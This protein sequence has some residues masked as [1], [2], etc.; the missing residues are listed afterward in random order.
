MQF[1]LHELAEFLSGESSEIPGPLITG[2]LPIEYGGPGV[3]TYI[4]DGQFLKRLSASSCGAVI[5]SAGVDCGQTPCIRSRNPEADYARLTSLYYS[6]EKPQWGISEKAHISDD[7]EVAPGVSIGP[8]AVIGSRARI[9]D[10]TVIDAHAVIGSDVTVGRDCKIFPHVVIYSGVNIGNRVIVH[11]GT[12]IGSDGF[13][14]ARDL[15][16]DGRPVNIKKY[17]HGTVEIGDDVEIGALCG[18]DRALAGSTVIG[19]G[20]KL[21]NLVQVAHNVVI[22]DGTVIASQAGIAG[23]SSIGK[24]GMVGGQAGVRDHVAVGNGVILATRVGIY[25][26]VPDGSVM[27]GSVPAMPHK[28]FLRAQSLFKRLPEIFERV[29]KLESSLHNK[30]KESL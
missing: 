25:R 7:A 3:I 4:S 10:G 23:S 8:F 5:I 11:S 22:G 9:G 21:D 2:V 6:Y 28:V 18:I 17:H 14:F 30:S 15:L 19:N 24:Y 20:V 1:S 16:P 13:G 27:A 26:N 12:V 29:R